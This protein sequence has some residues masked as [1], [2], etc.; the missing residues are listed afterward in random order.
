[1]LATD[2]ASPLAD[3]LRT[4]KRPKLQRSTA[5]GD[6]RAV[7]DPADRT[8]RFVMS[9][10]GV[11][12]DGNLVRNDGWINL[13]EFIRDNPALLWCHRDRDLPLGHWTNVFTDNVRTDWYEG[14][15]LVGDAQFATREEY[16]LADT[17]YRLYLGKHMR[18]V[19]IRWVPA[20]DGYRPLEDDK[21]RQIGWD[22][23]R[24]ELIE[25]SAVPVPADPQALIMATQRGLISGEQ[26]EKFV[27][28][29][30]CEAPE[31]DVY[32]LDSRE[33]VADAEPVVSGGD[34]GDTL[35]L[36]RAFGEIAEAIALR[37][38]DAPVEALIACDRAAGALATAR[39]LADR[40]RWC[41]EMNSECGALIERCA[42][43]LTD[44]LDATADVAEAL[45]YAVEPGTAPYSEDDPAEGDAADF[46][47]PDLVADD[48]DLRALPKSKKRKLAFA[49]DR[50]NDAKM[51]C[52]QA[53]NVIREVL[54]DAADG[55]IDG[56]AEKG[57]DQGR[58]D[59]G[60]ET[61]P[62]PLFDTALVTRLARIA[63]APEPTPAPPPAAAAYFDDDLLKRLA[64]IAS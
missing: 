13:K 35:D 32:V 20:E 61:P 54:A 40:L 43:S 23:Y 50:C 33:R 27:A 44:A 25:C 53:M 3:L 47:D 1:M 2:K 7:G 24:N 21:G 62:A 9:T 52:S 18:A 39:D 6:I 49:V 14:T 4:E 58:A 64:K 29:S 59:A 15:A 41:V 42:A 45:G 12:R 19:S 10:E 8:L 31:R 5:C 57:A 30:D 46:A 28:W 63:G 38:E 11:K 51:R 60:D 37:A 36:G 48:D 17:V 16:E 22:F 56:V 26:L 34:G 55:T